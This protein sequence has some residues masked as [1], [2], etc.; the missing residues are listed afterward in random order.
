MLCIYDVVLSCR[1]PHL[2][3]GGLLEVED[4]VGQH[5]HD[6][7]QAQRVLHAPGHAERCE[8][9]RGAALALHSQEE[10]QHRQVQDVAPALRMQLS[11]VSNGDKV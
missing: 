7:Q 3:D 11:A 4:A 2:P 1:G 10:Q 9:V 6:G 5:V 8:A